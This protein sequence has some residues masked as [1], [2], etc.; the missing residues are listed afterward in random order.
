MAADILQDTALRAV[1]IWEKKELP[2]ADQLSRWIYRVATNQA[3][4]QLRRQRRWRWIPWGDQMAVSPRDSSTLTACQIRDCLAQL[5]PRDAEALL[6][7][8]YA[9]WRYHEIAAAHGETEDAVRMRVAR[10]RKRFK[11]LYEMEGHDEA[12]LVS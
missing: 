8:L 5:K 7:N 10:A 4:D 9:G 12:T 11:L 2:P 1:H 3:R 6:L